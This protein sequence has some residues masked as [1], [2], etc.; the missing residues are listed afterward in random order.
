MCQEPMKYPSFSTITYSLF[1]WLLVTHRHCA[2]MLHDFVMIEFA[3]TTLTSLSLSLF[4]GN[5]ISR[6][7]SLLGLQAR[8]SEK[9]KQC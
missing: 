1:I 3:V 7:P 8:S 6:T 4:E 5:S 2:L 9:D